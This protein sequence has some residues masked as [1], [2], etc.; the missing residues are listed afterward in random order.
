MDIHRSPQRLA[1]GPRPELAYA[2]DVP[3]LSEGG[4]HR[5]LLLTNKRPEIDRYWQRKL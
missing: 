2:S 3:T 1:A 5:L 4:E